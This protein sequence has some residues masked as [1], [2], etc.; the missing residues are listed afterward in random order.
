M[1]TL[2]QS[3]TQGDSA[4]VQ[5]LRPADRGRARCWICCES[6]KVEQKERAGLDWMEMDRKERKGL[7]SEKI[8]QKK[9]LM[10]VI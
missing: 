3:Q 9:N 1:V 2:L 7:K 4:G 8:K 10:K 6:E 5:I